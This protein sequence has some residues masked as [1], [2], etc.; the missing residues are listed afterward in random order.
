M[1]IK[2][3]NR[4][5]LIIA[6]IVTICVISGALFAVQEI[7]TLHNYF[8]PSM[9]AVIENKVD[10]DEWN[11]V[12]IS[13]NNFLNFDSI[14]YEKEVVNDANSSGNITIRILDETKKLFWKK[15]Q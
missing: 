3:R 10:Q 11:R 8:Y 14:F 4:I 5:Q 9:G 7:G 15:R 1:K 13:D 2:R 6:V 12:R